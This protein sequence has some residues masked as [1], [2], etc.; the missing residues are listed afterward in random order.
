MDG[1]KENPAPGV[2]AGDGICALANAAMLDT[3]AITTTAVLI[4]L[5]DAITR[6][7]LDR[8]ECRQ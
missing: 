3:T 2:G 1:A 4:T 7:G 6:I 5:L 8:L